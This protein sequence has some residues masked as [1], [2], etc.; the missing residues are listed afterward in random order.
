MPLFTKSLKLK[1]FNDRRLGRYLLYALGEIV[2]VVAGILI[3][4]SINNHNEE[5]KQKKYLN[6]IFQSISADLERD[7]LIVGQAVKNYEQREEILQK[8]LNDSLSLED[9]K[10]CVL[11]TAVIS[12]YVPFDINDK[13]YLQLRDFNA[14][15]KEKDSLAVSLVQFYKSYQLT[16]TQLS[17]EIKNNSLEN[18]KYW[19][20][21]YPWFSSM[22]AN[23]QD[24]RI[25]D[26]MKNDPD[27]K[28]RAGYYNLIACKNFKLV[29]SLYKDDAIEALEEIE[30]RLQEAED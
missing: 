17:D 29:V 6:G 2:L 4:L 22:M 30:K 26:Y 11:C 27:F 28:N 25:A 7:T 8:I 19:R 21:H 14:T 24:D 12:S 1:S 20:D 9:Y 5:V 18:L 16:L 13:G 10:K 3:A 23:K 15:S